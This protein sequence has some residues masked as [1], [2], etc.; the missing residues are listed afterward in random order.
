MICRIEST[1]SVGEV[2]GSIAGPALARP[3]GAVPGTMPS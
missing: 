3:F 1:R 2:D